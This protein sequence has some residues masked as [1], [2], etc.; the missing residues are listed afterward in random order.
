[1]QVTIIG[2]GL[3]G[4]SMGGALRRAGLSVRGYDVA[5]TAMRIALLREL[6]DEMAGSL[7][8]AVEDADAVVL[9]VPQQQTVE[10]LPAVDAA[11]PGEAI[12]LDTASV[13]GQV[14]ATMSG[15]PGA[16]RAVGGHPLAGKER[17]G[18]EAAD[19]E[20]FRGRS[21]ALVP[22]PATEGET[23]DRAAALVVALG[24][25]PVIVTAEEHDRILARTSHL[26]QLLSTA[27]ALT[28]EPGDGRLAGPGLQDMTRLAMS[29]AGMWQEIL[30]ANRANVVGALRRL[31]QE[32]GDMT[33]AL[34]GSE[35]E[36]IARLMAEAGTAAE[37]AREGVTA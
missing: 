36:Q 4:G 37:S 34:E 19:P 7:E 27:L 14:L 32:L 30:A 24:A 22:N 18:P 6:I 17:S 25:T 33:D 26:P 15:L 20:L 16:R 21:F 28:L 11:A 12:L 31:L 13:K 8:A 3:I 5:P 1:M 10:L 29:P 2:L 35:L 9:A 23:L